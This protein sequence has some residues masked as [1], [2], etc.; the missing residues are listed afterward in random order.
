MLFCILI[1]AY[2]MTGDR[3]ETDSIHVRRSYSDLAS[4]LRKILDQPRFQRWM[5]GENVDE[6]RSNGGEGA[7]GGGL[8]YLLT[9]LGIG[10]L[11]A[12]VIFL[13]WGV[14]SSLITEAHSEETAGEKVKPPTVSSTLDEA[15]RLM[16]EGDLREA[17]RAFYLSTLLYLSERKILDY[18]RSLTNREYLKRLKSY[19]NLL[20]TFQTMV[21]IFDDIWYGQKRC[22]HETVVEYRRLA[23]RIR[24]VV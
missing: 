11:G 8:I 6:A 2:P 17:V 16:S 7:G 12:A 4:S 14:R 10:T 23:E 3:V 20:D 15:E 18:D 22:A 24:E 19:P 21:H 1:S 9:L 5:K 13:I